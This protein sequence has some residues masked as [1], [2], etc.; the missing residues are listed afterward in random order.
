MKELTDRQRRVLEFLQE[1]LAN[2]GM[3][4]TIREIGEAMGFTFPAARGH[5][6][7]LEKKG[8]LKLHAGKSRGIELLG[9]M[10][11]AEA[12]RGSFEHPPTHALP[13]AG[14]IRAGE[15]ITARQEIDSYIAVD[16]ELFRDPD[17]FVLRVVGESMVEAGI[18]EGDYVVVSGRSE[19]PR[20]AIGVALIEGAS[21]S[22]EGEATV[23]RIYKEG[24]YVRL[25]PENPTMSPTEH[26]SYDVRVLGRVTG[27][28]RKL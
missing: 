7:A 4:P 9:A 18:F 5:L 15:P 6:Q 2:Q 26:P 25:V 21:G 28:I 1:S 17:A 22:G 24:A 10:S 20:G 3:P 14:T 16:R 11:S 23:K 27:V 19:V 12:T 8:F 13:L